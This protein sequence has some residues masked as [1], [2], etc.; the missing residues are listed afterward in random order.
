MVE[1]E[2]GVD[3][4]GVE[5]NEEGL[6]V[7]GL[8]VEWESGVDVVGVELHGV[9]WGGVVGRPPVRLFVKVSRSKVERVVNERARRCCCRR[10]C[11]CGCRCRAWCFV[12]VSACLNL[13]QR[14]K[15]MWQKNQL[16]RAG[17]TGN[18]RLA[19]LTNSEADREI[20]LQQQKIE[21]MRDQLQRLMID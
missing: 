9:G 13:P 16:R 17:K 15:K 2:S 18:S 8:E 10:C 6:R 12:P 14:E 7:G 21:E 4:V 19:Y 20:S 3:V 11:G 1:W 5:W